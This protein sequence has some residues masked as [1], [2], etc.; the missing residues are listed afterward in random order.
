MKKKNGAGG[1]RLPD[2]RLYY[3]ATV[4]KTIWYWPK[5]RNID[6][7]NRIESPEINPGTYG[8]LIYDKG[9]KDIQWRK[10]SLFNKWCLENWTATCKTMKLE[11]SLTPYTKINSKWI[12]DVDVRLETIK[13]LKENIG[14]SLFEINHSNIS[15][16]LSPKAK[17]INAKINK[18]AQLGLKA[19][20]QQR[21]PSTK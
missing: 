2:F 19:F 16:G 9:G 4:I 21:K 8:Q 14:R 17:E 13:L 15:L 5:N 11:H 7:W 10:D 3:K 20:A 18:W 1:I 12:K 6:Q